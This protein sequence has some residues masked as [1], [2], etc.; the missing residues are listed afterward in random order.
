MKKIWNFLKANW[1]WVVAAILFLAVIIVLACLYSNSQKKLKAMKNDY[2][3]VAAE[4]E[5]LIAENTILYEEIGNLQAQDSLCQEA[6][7][8]LAQACDQLR[9]KCDSLQTARRTVR[10][11]PVRRTTPVARRSQPQRQY[12][13]PDLDW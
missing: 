13:Y 3:I 4:N 10:P 7:E 2:E 6:N 1:K 9:R 12:Q 8:S 11:T 5:S